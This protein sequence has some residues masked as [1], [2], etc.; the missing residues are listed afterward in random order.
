MNGIATFRLCS[1]TDGELV[2]KV[3]ELADNMFKTGKIPP[4]RVPARPDEDFDL[5]IGELMLRFM[6]LVKEKKDEEKKAKANK[7][8]T[9]E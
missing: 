2:S 6:E 9:S 4:R 5:L 3:D 8:E 1:L 7:Q